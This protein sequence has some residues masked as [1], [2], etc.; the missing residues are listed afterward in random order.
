MNKGLQEKLEGVEKEIHNLE[1]EYAKNGANRGKME[2]QLEGLLKDYEELR[3]Q[4]EKHEK[5]FRDFREQSILRRDA[6]IFALLSSLTVGI[7]MFLIGKLV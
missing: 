3:M 2:M 5:N 7:I 6:W 1:L 4:L